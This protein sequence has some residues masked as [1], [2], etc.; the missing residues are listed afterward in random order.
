MT[1]EVAVNDIFRFLQLRPRRTVAEARSIPLAWS[2]ELVGRLAGAGSVSKRVEVAN[3]ALGSSPV[4]AVADVPLGPEI[5]E[6]LQSLRELEGATT[7]DLSQQL[8][9]LD[10]MRRDVGFVSQLGA[11][12]DTLLAVVFATRG[13]PKS[14]DVLQDIYRVYHLPARDDKQPDEYPSVPLKRFLA[15]P[16]LAPTL[17][18]HV[19]SPNPTPISRVPVASPDRSALSGAISELARLDRR[20]LLVQPDERGSARR[21]TVPFT[22]TA[23]ARKL[24]SKETTAVLKDRGIDLAETPIDAAVQALVE[25]TLSLPVKGLKWPR[26]VVLPQ[27]GVTLPPA[28][29]PAFVQPAGVADLLVVKQQIK[30]YEAGEIAHVENILIGEKKSRAHR[31][32]ERSEETFLTETETTRTQETELETADRF[33]LNRETSRTIKNDQKIG[34]GLSLSG[35]Y[36]PS[37]EFSTTFSAE[38]SSSQEEVA[39]NA[40]RYAKD[41]INRSLE[42]LTERVREVRTRT[43]I[44]ETEETNL[45][46][47]DNQTAKHISGIYQFLDKVYEAQVFNYGI[48]EMFDFMIPEP[49]SFLWYVEQNP[50]LDVDLPPPPEKLEILC[51]DAS[52]ITEDN[53]FPLAAEFGADI[54]TPP[55]MYTLVTAGVKHGEDN[56]S[57]SGQ[58]RSVQRV[59]LTVSAGYRPL[60]ARIRGLAL[61]DQNPVIAVT[62][63]DMLALWRPTS[64]DRSSLSGGRSLAHQPTL[65]MDLAA[66][67]FRL[68]A[69]SKLGVSIVA[70]ETNTYSLDIVV[71]TKRTDEDLDRW[72]LATY[73]KIRSAYEDRVREH[74]QKVEQLRSEAE[75][76]AE[77][78]RRLPFGSPPAV[79][80]LTVTTEL[81]KHCI[82]IITQQRYDAFDATKD[83][84][85]PYFDFNEA[86]AEGAYIRFFEQAF[87]WD[88]MQYVF[89]PYFWSRKTT[90]VERFTKQEVDPLFLEFLRAGS[91]RVVVPVRPGFEVAVTHF[92][93]TGKLWSGE[94]QPPRINSPLYVSIIDEIRERTGA[95]KG[96]IPVGDPWD[97]RVPTAL[98]LVRPNSDLP[99]WKRTAP[100]EWDWLPDEGV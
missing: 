17:P 88:Q 9:D 82:T 86:A 77:R 16:L 43:I 96:E 79:N 71:V 15:R 50:T 21:N 35:K 80:R 46:E 4:Q 98:V 49:A 61:T 40:S 3:A 70:Y 32:L 99:K 87:E 81:K 23:A 56:A 54:E 78:E 63:G 60:R 92:L 84:Q 66:E 6:T 67:P 55:P 90:W 22:L 11:L 76:K 69:E 65:F 97:A 24:L 74:E 83:G 10:A 1:D 42:R 58:P 19:D 100:E 26:P 51:P 53:A 37:V 33:E 30:R 94:G 25:E 13:F 5:A 36:G 91:A 72:R 39:K 28:T 48:R 95:P 75:A 73:K 8:P 29:G 12:S 57:E 41:V 93:E 59:D 7:M 2:T 14:I 68:S 47:L 62:I 85:P 20:E 31:Q 45:H 34:F 44:R 38:T 64:A 52:H 18:S 27:L 89:Y